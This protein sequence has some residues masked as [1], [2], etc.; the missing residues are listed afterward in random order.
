MNI[1]KNRFTVCIAVLFVI[2][3]VAFA[4]RMLGITKIPVFADEAIYIRWSQVM[5]AEPTLRFLPLSDGKQ[6]LFMWMVIPFLKIFHNPL[7]SGR[8]TSALAGMG[9]LLG[10]VSLS[11]LISRSKKAALLSAFLYCLSPFMFFFDRMALVDSLLSCF[12]VWF[13]VLLIASI[14]YLRLDFALL[15]GFALGGALLTKSPA[16]FFAILTPLSLFFVP[17]GSKKAPLL[18]FQTIGLWIATLVV[19][20]GM[21]QI[22]R[23]GPNYQMIAIRNLD[24]VF[25]LSHVITNTKDPFIFNLDRAFEWMVILAP[26][27]VLLLALIGYLVAIKKLSFKILVLLIAFAFPLLVGSMYSKSFTTRYILFTLPPLFVLAGF[28]S[29]LKSKW[30]LLIVGLFVV[31]A[32]Y[33]DVLLI[34]NPVNAPLPESERSG[35]FEEWSSGF[36]ILESANIIK[37]EA[38]AHPDEHIIVGTEGYFG[39]LPDGLQIYLEK[40]PNVVVVGT[41]LNFKSIPKELIEAKK[42]GAKTYFVVNS[43]RLNPEFKRDGLTLLYSFVKPMRMPGTHEYVSAGP[44][45]TFYFFEL[46][47]VK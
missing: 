18:V 22:L 45:E 15:A 5:R 17:W 6:P 39:T 11:Y 31:H 12:G 29:F 41:G 25:P 1:F 40:I 26:F 43:S 16:L 36:G 14:K 38:T 24:Y 32:L 23:L 8:V 4:I 34:T 21:A 44:Q 46:N 47:S 20:Y 35:Y 37:E 30:Y 2:V 3:A 9:T 13:L 33:F 10:I 27:E 19:G 28:S 42:S 7:V